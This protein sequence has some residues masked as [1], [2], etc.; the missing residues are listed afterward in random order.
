MTLLNLY[1][2]TSLVRFF[3]SCC[4]IMPSNFVSV[5]LSHHIWRDLI[6]E[7][8]L[9]QYHIVQHVL[10]IFCL[11]SLISKAPRRVVACGGSICMSGPGDPFLVPLLQ[12]RRPVVEARVSSQDPQLRHKSVLKT[13]VERKCSFSFQ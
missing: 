2:A 3:F 4:T 1:F 11:V 10:Y 6:Y 12:F 5:R 9:L 13:P 8:F 7:V